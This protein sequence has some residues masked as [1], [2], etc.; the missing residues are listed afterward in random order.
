MPGQF[1][2]LDHCSTQARDELSFF[3]APFP[4]EGAGVDEGLRTAG[5]FGKCL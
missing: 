3:P 1:Q 5:E 2:F 4:P